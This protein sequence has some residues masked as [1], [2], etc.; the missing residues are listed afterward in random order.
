MSH[1][2]VGRSSSCST[3]VSVARASRTGANADTMSDTGAITLF[4][5]PASLQVVRI[6]SESLPTGMAIPSLGHSSF[7]TAC[8]VA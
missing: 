1:S 2:D 4:C 7:A 6:D 3:G 5:T 8:T